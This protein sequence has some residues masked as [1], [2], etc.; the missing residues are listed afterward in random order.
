MV[1][2]GQCQLAINFKFENGNV[3]ILNDQ[4]HH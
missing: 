3:F 2:Y 1:N 4:D